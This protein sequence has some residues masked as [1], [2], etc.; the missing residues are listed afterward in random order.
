MLRTIAI[1]GA[2]VGIATPTHAQVPVPRAAIAADAP[3]K[4]LSPRSQF[5][6]RWDGIAAHKEAYTKSFWGDVMKGPTGASVRALF[7]EWPKML[8]RDLLTNQLL[9]GQSPDQLKTRMTDVKNVSGLLDLLVEKGVV[10]GAEVR[11]PV[12][13]FKGVARAFESVVSGEAPSVNEFA[14]SLQLIV[15]VPDAGDRAEVLFSTLRLVVQGKI[16]PFEAAG[17]KG[18]TAV[19]AS[20]PNGIDLRGA[21]WMEGRHFVFCGGTF[22]PADAVAGIAANTAA[23]GVTTQPL[24]EKC[25]KQQ[26]FES[27]ARGFIDA[28][29]LAGLMKKLGG[30]F[31]PGL[32][33]RFDDLG[34]GNV[35]SIVFSSGFHGKESRAMYEIDLTGEPKG[36]A[37]I[38]KNE[39][40]RLAD[41]P[42][43][44]P[45]VSCFSALR[46]DPAAAYDATIVAVEALFAD[47][48]LGPEDEARSPAEKIRLRQEFLRQEA[49]RLAGSDLSKTLL[50]YLG[51]KFVM[52]KSPAEGLSILGTVFCISVKDVA[53][54][55]SALDRLQRGVQ[56]A[57][58]PPVRVRKKT[59][60]GVEIREH[61]SQTFS[62][63]TPTYSIC[64]DWLV[65][66]LHPQ[67]VQGFVLRCKGELPVWKPDDATRARLNTLPS[68]GCGLQF[69]DPR[70]T[71]QNLCCIGPPGLNVLLGSR[72]DDQGGLEG[73]DIGLLPNAHELN[74]HLFP[75]LTVTRNDGKTI[76]IEV[77]ESLSL[78]LEAIGIESTVVGFF[79]VGGSFLR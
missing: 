13:T 60:N 2:L 20:A 63:L 3:E 23:G 64:G 27:V 49:N 42:P 31:M 9:E 34:F 30:A 32:V 52:Y 6:F 55:K 68:D 47:T 28:A 7:A 33:R 69:C 54:V 57:G 37:K 18:Y 43:V 56:A 4:L 46:I 75:N 51:D 44:P 38:L 70:P 59:L 17:R 67:S 50:P 39:P 15:I 77:N 24:F 41:L 36:L 53:K 16:E 25:G 8:G 61:Y 76:R 71:V 40:L 62:F 74:K 12:L 58:G 48:Q 14:P 45:D 11:E 65:V 19:P 1:A 73:P 79:A 29:A 72:T 22:K 66:G 21:W 26:P 35:K 78:S 5:F 10:V